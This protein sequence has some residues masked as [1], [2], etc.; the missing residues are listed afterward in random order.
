[1]CWQ[2]CLQVQIQDVQHCI[3]TILANLALDGYMK[4]RMSDDSNG[5][6]VLQKVAH[7]LHS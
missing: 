1:M 4:Q 2:A 7:H 3:F 6:S 5:Q